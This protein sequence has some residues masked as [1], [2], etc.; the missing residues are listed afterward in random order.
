[1]GTADD[2]DDGVGHF[3]LFFFFLL[4]GQQYRIKSW[5]GNKFFLVIVVIPADAV[6]FCKP[7]SFLSCKG[8]PRVTPWHTSWSMSPGRVGAVLQLDG[9]ILQYQRVMLV[10]CSEDMTLKPR[11]K[12]LRT[13]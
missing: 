10:M 12:W 5:E 6:M 7:F 3:D 4:W 11:W 13:G 1:M 9:R 8:I 2:A